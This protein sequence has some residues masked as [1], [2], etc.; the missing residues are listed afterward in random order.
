MDAKRT[1]AEIL[2]DNPLQMDGNLRLAAD[3]LSEAIELGADALFY[4]D[5]VG[6]MD[7]KVHR[8]KGRE[9]IVG[10]VGRE[11]DSALGEA[12]NRN[13]YLVREGD[14]WVPTTTRSM[15]ET[16]GIKLCPA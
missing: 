7:S 12:Y 13:F 3:T 4:D 16:Y 5:G 14:Q 15:C 8:L 2:A 11:A 10:H 9:N 1:M 6:V